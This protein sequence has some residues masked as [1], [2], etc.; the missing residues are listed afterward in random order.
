MK[1]TFAASV[2]GNSFLSCSSRLIPEQ[3]QHSILSHVRLSHALATPR[4]GGSE[5][6]MTCFAWKHANRN[7]ILVRRSDL[8]KAGALGVLTALTGVFYLLDFSWV[9]YRKAL[10]GDD[11]EVGRRGEDP[12]EDFGPPPA[13]GRI[14]HVSNR[15][16]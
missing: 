2:R 15:Y 10:I 14:F 6:G 13:S 7:N 12:V 1:C 3:A 4:H 8:T 16:Y 11:E 5:T 9:I